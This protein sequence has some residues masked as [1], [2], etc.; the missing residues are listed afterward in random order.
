MFHYKNNDNDSDDDESQ[1]ERKLYN[2]YADIRS[3]VEDKM[4]ERLYA[5]KLKAQLDRGTCKNKYL[6]GL[7]DEVKEIKNNSD[8]KNLWITVNPQENPEV[9]QDLQLAIE[10]LRYKKFVL[11]LQ[12]SFEQR[13]ETEEDAGKGV[14][15]HMLLQRDL[16]TRY[17]NVK[18]SIHNIFDKLC[19]N[20]LHVCI[21]PCYDS[22]VEDKVS[23]LQGQKWDED[24]DDKVKYD[25]L[26]R[27]KLGLKPTYTFSK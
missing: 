4:Y 19:G 5:L 13:G 6:I 2:H 24:K 9:L 26:W 8:I 22:W 1:Y 10:K 11:K 14:H 27:D 21:K 17:D 12:Y 20:S 16:S 18:R 7:Y 3:K 23:Y 15:L 25:K